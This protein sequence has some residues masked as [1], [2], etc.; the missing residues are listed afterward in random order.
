MSI[1]SVTKTNTLFKLLMN[2]I[3]TFHKGFYILK[4][5]IVFA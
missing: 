4:F 5:I 1:C 3:K 2:E